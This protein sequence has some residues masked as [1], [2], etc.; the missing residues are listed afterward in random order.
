MKSYIFRM[1]F[2]MKFW[3]MFILYVHLLTAGLQL[4]CVTFV[5]RL[6]ALHHFNQVE[7]LSIFFFAEELEPLNIEWST[8]SFVP[9]SKVF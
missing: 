2:I 5:G 3:E 4:A 7:S 8:L 9:S 6:L 1:C